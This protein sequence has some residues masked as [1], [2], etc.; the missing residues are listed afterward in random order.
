HNYLIPLCS[1]GCIYMTHTDECVPL[2]QILS[3]ESAIE[4]YSRENNLYSV[5]TEQKLLPQQAQKLQ[6]NAVITQ[7]LLHFTK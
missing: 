7:V 3:L 5:E 2:F 6:V 1:I 4:Q